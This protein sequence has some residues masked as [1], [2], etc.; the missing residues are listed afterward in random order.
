M[1]NY[2]Y[3]SLGTWVIAALQLLSRNFTTLKA[4]KEIT[5]TVTRQFQPTLKLHQPHHQSS[6][7]Y[8]FIDI[9]L[10]TNRIKMY[11]YL[12]ASSIG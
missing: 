1:S 2:A 3:T 9:T 6:F 11:K 4:S 8:V 10:S 12:S 5:K 7:E